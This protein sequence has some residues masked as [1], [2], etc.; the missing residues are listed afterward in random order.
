MRSL[1][2]LAAVVPC[3]GMSHGGHAM[4]DMGSGDMGSGDMGS[5]GASSLDYLPDHLP[6]CIEGNYPLFKTQAMAN[7]ATSMGTSH[8]MTMVEASDVTMY[9]PN[10]NYPGKQMSGGGHGGGHGNGGGDH[11]DHSGHDHSRRLSSMVMCPP[12]VID[13]TGASQLPTTSFCALGPGGMA[14]YPL[15]KTAALA[16]AAAG[17]M[18]MATAQ[19]F[20]NF[21]LYFAM[22]AANTVGAGTSCASSG[23]TDAT[24]ML[25]ESYQLISMPMTMPPS[26]PPPLAP[27]NGAGSGC[28][29]PARPQSCTPPRR[30]PAPLISS[31]PLCAQSPAQSLAAFSYQLSSASS[32]SRARLRPSA[33]RPS[34]P[35][36]PSWALRAWAIADIQELP[37]WL[38][39]AAGQPAALCAH[40]PRVMIYAAALATCSTTSAGTSTTPTPV[41][42]VA[43]P[44]A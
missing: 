25:S 18:N 4:H 5:G 35:P 23:L 7:K 8:A 9:M 1:Y 24:A 27:D 32:G 16:A 41:L 38:Y 34:S 36:S 17:G 11:D 44:V 37:L 26:M 6:V 13:A 39:D 15:Y 30:T 22:G 21:T 10:G 12:N 33:P 14:Y 20:G 28:R 31:R 40:E 43:V 2:L 3:L 19:S 42:A 29:P